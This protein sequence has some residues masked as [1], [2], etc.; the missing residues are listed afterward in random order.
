M[1]QTEVRE[2]SNTLLSSITSCLKSCRL[3][4]NA[5]KHSKARDATGD[6]II[7][8]MRFACWMRSYKHILRMCITYCFSTV[9]MV[10]RT[11]LNVVLFIYC[12]CCIIFS[13]LYSTMTMFLDV[14]RHPKRVSAV[15]VPWHWRVDLTAES[16]TYACAWYCYI[17]GRSGH[18]KS[19][20]VRTLQSEVILRETFCCKRNYDS[21]SY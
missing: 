19:H 18:G 5:E 11:H 10:T 7:Q 16:R 21:S 6:D 14:R 2:N 4:D 13:K 20:S 12:L 15:I 9:R 17:A 3:W 8:R 1:F